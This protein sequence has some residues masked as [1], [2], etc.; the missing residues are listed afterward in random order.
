M[1]EQDMLSDVAMAAMA[2]FLALALGAGAGMVFG[3]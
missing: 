2:A 1:W 3:S